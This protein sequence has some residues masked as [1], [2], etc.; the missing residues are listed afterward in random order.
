[1][2]ND[3]VEHARRNGEIVRRMLRVAKLLAQCS[4][5]GR[6]LVSA[7]DVMQERT[8]LGE[9]FLVESA[10][11]FDAVARTSLELLQVPSRLG[12][13]DHRNFKMAAPHHR[14]QRGEDFLERQVARGAEEDQ[15]VGVSAVHRISSRA[16]LFRGGFFEVAAKLKTQGG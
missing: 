4:E 6:V 7:V 1:L 9:W 14:L 10:M 5:G 13:A 16:R 2:L 15:G 8:E 3:H 12:D 11:F